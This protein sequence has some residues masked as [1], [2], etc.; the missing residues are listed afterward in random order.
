MGKATVVHLATMYTI[1][2]SMAIGKLNPIAVLL[3]LQNHYSQSCI[4]IGF[5]RCYV[6]NKGRDPIA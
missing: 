5:R 2:I 6:F 4:A 3:V 1:S